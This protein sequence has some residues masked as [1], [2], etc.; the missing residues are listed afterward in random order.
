MKNTNKH[1]HSQR[2]LQSFRGLK[3][4]KHYWYPMVMNA[5]ATAPRMMHDEEPLIT[6]QKLGY[7]PK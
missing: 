3:T 4:N 6:H 1:M 5:A 2:A 7:N